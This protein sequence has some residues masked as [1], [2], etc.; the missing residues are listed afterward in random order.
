[1]TTAT[2][3]NDQALIPWWLILLEG[4]SLVILGL[5]FLRWSVYS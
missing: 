4:I 3:K 2:V 5:F 1:M